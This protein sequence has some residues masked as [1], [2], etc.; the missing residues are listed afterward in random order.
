MA[1][2]GM[3]LGLTA[4][5]HSAMPEQV[6]HDPLQIGVAAML[7]LALSKRSAHE[8]PH[9]SEYAGVRIGRITWTLNP[10]SRA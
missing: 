9:L 2:P 4:A 6:I 3:P 1:A 5:A 8:V 7:A 10:C